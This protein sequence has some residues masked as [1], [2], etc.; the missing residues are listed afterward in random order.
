MIENCRS[1]IGL[2][3]NEIN[4]VSS[5]FS[6]VRGTVPPFELVN[7][8]ILSEPDIKMIGLTSDLR[9]DTSTAVRY[10]NDYAPCKTPSQILIELLQRMAL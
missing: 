1:I 3:W 8:I 5:T 10:S 6:S 7:H 4:F 2:L 9:A